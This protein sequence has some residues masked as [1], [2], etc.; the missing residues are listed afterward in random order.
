[1]WTTMKNEK[2]TL[3]QLL[4]TT[5]GGTLRF[6]IPLLVESYETAQKCWGKPLRITG[7]NYQGLASYSNVTILNMRSI[8]WTEMSWTHI[9]RN[10]VHTMCNG[11]RMRSFWVATRHACHQRVMVLN[12]KPFGNW[13]TSPI[14]ICKCEETRPWQRPNTKPGMK[15]N[16]RRLTYEIMQWNSFRVILTWMWKSTKGTKQKHPR[17]HDWTSVKGHCY[18]QGESIHSQMVW[19]TIWNETYWGSNSAQNNRNWTYDTTMDPIEDHM[20]MHMG[21]HKAYWLSEAQAGA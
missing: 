9:K 17:D 3:V 4:D 18:D 15:W 1:M 16:E 7:P 6:V 10:M 13:Y 19:A 20:E 11:S 14:W 2:G 8:T 21:M 12:T 5:I